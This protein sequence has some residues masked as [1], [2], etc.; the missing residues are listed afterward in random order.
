MQDINKNKLLQAPALKSLEKIA[1]EIELLGYCTEKT[2]QQIVDEE[3]THAA[4][5]LASVCYETD[6]HRH[7]FLNSN[8]IVDEYGVSLGGVLDKGIQYIEAQ[9]N[10]KPGWDWELRRRKIEKHN[11]ESIKNMPEGVLCMEISS[12]DT[13][14]PLAELKE[15]GYS[16]A[17]LIRVSY[18]KDSNK[19]IQRNI[20]LSS[21]D[22]KILN[23]LRKLVDPTS[24]KLTNSEDFLSSPLFIS[25]NQ[26]SFEGFI[27]KL[28][29]HVKKEESTKNPLN[30][31][32]NA[33]KNS[34]TA[35]KNSWDLVKDHQIFEEM[36]DEM[37]NLAKLSNFS[38]KEINLIRAGA[39]QV[40]IDQIK[41]ND[42]KHGGCSINTGK[43]KAKAMGA[44][45]TSC[46]GTISFESSTLNGFFSY[47]DR[48]N[49]AAS[50]LNRIDKLGCCKACGSNAFMYGCGVYC[51]GCNTIW[52]NE[53]IETG[54]QLSNQE[55][56]EKKYKFYFGL[57]I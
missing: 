35:K 15:W 43:A 41:N 37:V 8:D 4:E 30:Y 18:K 36:F 31:V 53:Y 20:M 10:Q 7:Y 48:Y 26:N 13:T 47:F 23:T 51:R 14:K 54:K 28:K 11:F 27:A 33:F 44:V 42:N 19:I 12:T 45:F 38:D 2:K 29:N 56:L 52:C 5:I 16:G 50:L 40:L 3:K 55:V 22:V 49:T 1:S 46:G 17:S 6:I 32:L 21:S 39:W 34:L 24:F 9:G 57:K 25:V